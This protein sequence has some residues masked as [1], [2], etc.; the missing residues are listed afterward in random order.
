MQTASYFINITPASSFLPRVTQEEKLPLN[1]LF[2]FPLSF[3]VL[4]ANE[5]SIVLNDIV[6]SDDEDDN[7]NNEGGGS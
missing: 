5:A 7:V 2:F 1:L 6:I 3:I 4:A